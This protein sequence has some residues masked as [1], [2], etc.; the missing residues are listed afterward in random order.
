MCDIL[1]DS[2]L[3]KTK[4]LT[5]AVSALRRFRDTISRTINELDLFERTQMKTFDTIGSDGFR[6]SWEEYLADI[7]H[8]KTE[9]MS[10]QLL[11]IQK[12][13][14]FNSLLAGV[15]GERLVH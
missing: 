12:F 4:E 3:T 2:E 1:D 5:Q 6:Q 14:L 13:E 10:M 11:L 15:C 7:R 9:M 8:S